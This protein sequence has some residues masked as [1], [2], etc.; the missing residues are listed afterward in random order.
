MKKTEFSPTNQI[1]FLIAWF[2]FLMILM[3]VPRIL[4][5]S[6]YNLIWSTSKI[7]AESSM[8]FLNQIEQIMI[9]ASILTSVLCIVLCVTDKPLNYN[10]K[11]NCMFLFPVLSSFM[12]GVYSRYDILTYLALVYAFIPTRVFWSLESIKLLLN[13]MRFIL[14]LITAIIELG[15]GVSHPVLKAISTG[16]ITSILF[17]TISTSLEKIKKETKADV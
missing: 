5:F 15:L 17:D 6:L 2:V 8:I 13:T 9:V 11:L 4:V 10:Q 14:M 7:I 1:A 3:F 12:L 16:I